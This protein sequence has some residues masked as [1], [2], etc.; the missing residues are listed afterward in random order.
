MYSCTS[1]FVLAKGQGPVLIHQDNIFIPLNQEQKWKKI[2]SSALLYRSLN[3]ILMLMNLM[4]VINE[5]VTVTDSTGKFIL[6]QLLPIVNASVSKRKF[7]ASAYTGDPPSASPKYWLA[8][9]A[10]VPPLGFSTYVISSGQCEP[11]LLIFKAV[12]ESSFFNPVKCSTCLNSHML[13]SFCFDKNNI[14]HV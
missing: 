8:F 12:T 2:N 5:N 1:G 11:D 3:K 4:Q 7:Y 14:I 6:S 9:T 13:S 10:V